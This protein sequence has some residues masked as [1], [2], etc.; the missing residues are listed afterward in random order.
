MSDI[1]FRDWSHDELAKFTEF[2]IHNYRVMDAFWFINLENDYG[3]EEAC[4]VN[5]LVWGRSAPWP[6]GTLKRDLA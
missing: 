2:L 5:E 4:R 6:P 3:M 1:G